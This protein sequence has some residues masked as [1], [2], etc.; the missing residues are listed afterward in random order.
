MGF[1]TIIL[2]VGVLIVD[3]IVSIFAGM[4]NETLSFGNSR[5]DG[6]K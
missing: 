6:D 5:K 3:F 2:I 4:K 1:F